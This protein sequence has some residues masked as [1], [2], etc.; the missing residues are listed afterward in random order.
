M[1]NQELNLKRTILDDLRRMSSSKKE[2][3]QQATYALVEQMLV[4]KNRATA[5]N[6]KEEVQKAARDTVELLN[7]SS[8]DLLLLL[9]SLD[10]QYFLKQ[11]SIDV[12]LRNSRK[13][14]LGISFEQENQILLSWFNKMPV[15]SVLR[16]FL[17]FTCVGTSDPNVY[18]LNTERVRKLFLRYFF[19]QKESVYTLW[20]VKYRNKLRP[21][22]KHLLGK[23][24]YSAL[25][26]ILAMS[27]I[28]YLTS[29]ANDRTIKL[30]NSVYKY[31]ENKEA[32]YESLAFIL[33][34]K[35]VYSMIPSCLIFN[36]YYSSRTNK[37]QLKRLPFEVAWG[38]AKTYHK[39]LKEADVLEMTQRTMSAKEQVRRSTTTAGRAAHISADISALSSKE[40]FLKVYKQGRATTEDTVAL[41]TKAVENS[42]MVP[43]STNRYVGIILDTSLSM[44][45]RS[46]T[47]LHPMADALTLKNALVEKAE[48]EN[49]EVCVVRTNNPTQIEEVVKATS[50]IP[51]PQG[52]S[53]F[54]IALLTLLKEGCQDIYLITDGYENGEGNLLSEV[55]VK[56]REICDFSITQLTVSVAAEVASSRSIS[57]NIANIAV[58]DPRNIR[59]QL[60]LEYLRTDFNAGVKLLVDTYSKKLLA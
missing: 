26:N 38:I 45:G 33:G 32:A 18:R 19:S 51:K 25:Y 23:G 24:K 11:V 60:L 8:R 30:V 28:R 5:Y 13:S 50:F 3:I 42:Q 15:T 31:A 6:S 1:M 34:S 56:A 57:R 47:H 10:S 20:A 46:D 22:F 21:I 9:M 54:T 58:Q 39:D 43:F 27:W 14:T 17:S 55:V 59:T 16:L 53:S 12:L 36:A 4:S 40:I 44:Q 49:V 52:D 41:Q 37:M 2:L 35:E 29:V 7:N 48:S